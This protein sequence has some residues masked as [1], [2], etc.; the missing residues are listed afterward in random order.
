MGFPRQE[1][2]SRLPFPSPGDLPNPG[3]EFTSPALA[4]DFFTAEASGKPLTGRKTEAQGEVVLGGGVHR[5]G[6][7]QGAVC[8]IVIFSGHLM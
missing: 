1:Y 7:W 4:G 3:I 6:K 2:Y 8:N 5:A